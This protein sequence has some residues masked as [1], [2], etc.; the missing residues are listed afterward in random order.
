M[1]KKSSR[2]YVIKKMLLS[3]MSIVLKKKYDLSKFRERDII[4]TFAF[5]K[6]LVVGTDAAKWLM[7]MYYSKRQNA[8]N[9]LIELDFVVLNKPKKR[10]AKKYIKRQKE[11]DLFYDS[12][13]WKNLRKKIFKAYGRTCMCCRKYSRVMHIDHIMPR[14]KYPYLELEPTNMQVLCRKCNEDKSNKHS[15]DYR[16]AEQ[17]M[18]FFVN[19]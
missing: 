9:G 6:K 17:R 3:Q 2:K 14:S 12:D 11:R 5:E 13:A 19:T 7:D 1:N 8:I 4:N 16:T 15:T 10:L 18:Y